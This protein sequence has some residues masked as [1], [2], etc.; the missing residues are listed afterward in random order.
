[1]FDKLFGWIKL[2]QFNLRYLGDPPWDTGIPV[3]EL[4][5]YIEHHEPGRALDLGCGTGTNMLA[6]LR[7]GWRVDGVDIAFLATQKAKDKTKGYKGAA[8]VYTRHVRSL[9]VLDGKYDLIYD[10]GCYH[11]LNEVDR[12][13]YR[14]NLKTL[15]RMNGHYLIY[16]FYQKGDEKFGISQE[17]ISNFSRFMR[18]NKHLNSTD[19]RGRA[20]VC[21]EF[22]KD[23]S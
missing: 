16:G 12:Q 11:A 3:P 2:F 20:A 1:M 9:G 15:L 23:P 4:V 18:K 6:F 21:L 19:E 22:C 8:N 17:D 13:R 5:E 10:I 7:A 14:E